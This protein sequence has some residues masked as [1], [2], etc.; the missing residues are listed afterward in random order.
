MI[1]LWTVI[2]AVVLTSSLVAPWLFWPYI[3][4]LFGLVF[5]GDYHVRLP[6]GYK[7]MTTAGWETLAIA[8]NEHAVILPTIDGYRIHRG[9]VFG[10]VR[11][12][13]S[14]STPG[15]FILDTWTGRKWVGLNAAEWREILGRYGITSIPP[16]LTP[17]KRSGKNSHGRASGQ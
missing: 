11:R 8:R 15:Y 6:N 7:L 9:I 3:Y 5:I 4:L 1:R 10:H 17:G 13:D 14:I 16:L 12:L 2:G